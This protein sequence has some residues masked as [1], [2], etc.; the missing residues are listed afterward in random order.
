MF[1]LN[2]RVEYFNDEKGSRGLGAS[3]YEAT[4]GV[5]IHPMPNDKILS[6]LMFRPEV[7]YDY[8]NQSIFDGGTG[9]YQFTAAID[10]IFT[11]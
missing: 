2:G 9:N 7:R 11:F 4:A 10:A 5:A 8:A 1:T 6:N 3:V